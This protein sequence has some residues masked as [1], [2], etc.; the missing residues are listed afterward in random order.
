MEECPNEE[1]RGESITALNP[2]GEEAAVRIAEGRLSLR[3]IGGLAERQHESGAQR[4][5]EAGLRGV[6]GLLDGRRVL[7]CRG[8][9]RNE[10]GEATCPK[11][12]F[13]RVPSIEGQR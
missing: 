13:H 2:D 5:L 4:E 3:P 1:V 6:V 10:D 11:R 9:G 8:G 7:L 12:R